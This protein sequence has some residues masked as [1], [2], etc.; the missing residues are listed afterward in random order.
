METPVRKP[1]PTDLTVWLTG[2]LKPGLRLAL[3]SRLRANR[4]LR[5]MVISLSV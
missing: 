3:E 4:R 5:S 1:D 2:R